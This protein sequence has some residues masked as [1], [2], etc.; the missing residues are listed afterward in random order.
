MPLPSL[1]RAVSIACV[2]AATVAIAQDSSM[3]APRVVEQKERAAPRAESVNGP[4]E[5]IPYSPPVVPRP[6][7]SSDQSTDLDLNPQPGDIVRLLDKDGQPTWTIWGG[8]SEKFRDFL[9]AQNAAGRNEPEFSISS[10]AM[11]GDA[12]DDRARLVAHITIQVERDAGWLSVSLGMPE[13][14]RRPGL[15]HTGP[16]DFLPVVPVNP[17]AGHIVRLRGKGVHE[18]TFPID[19]PIRR[20]LNQRHL[21][22]TIPPAA[23]SE[24]T[25]R[26]PK[27]HCSPKPI[28]GA[29]VHASAIPKGTQIE[30]VGVKGQFD[31]AWDSPVDEPQSRSV[32]DVVDKLWLRMDGDR[33]HLSAVQTI[34]PKRGELAA[35]K[36]RIPS[37][38]RTFNGQQFYV[39][40][41]KKYAATDRDGSGFVKVD[42]KPAGTSPLELHWEL[43]APLQPGSSFVLRGLDVEGARSESGD[44]AITPSEGFHF[45]YR[46]GRNVRRINVTG[47]GIGFAESAYSFW[48]PF[49]LELSLEEIRPQFSVEPTLYL[50]LSERQA[51]LTGQI[52]VQIHQGALREMAFNWP[53]WKKQ[54]WTVD[55]LP[56]DTEIVNADSKS[57]PADGTLRFR[58]IG[59]RAKDF[60][61]S[62]RA[63]RSIPR[64]GGVFQL[65]L[66]VIM[67][68]VRPSNILIVAEA[69]NVKSSFEPRP[70]T[71]GSSIASSRRDT[72][73]F[74][75]SVRGLRYS[76]R[77]VESAVQAFD[78]T[79]SPQKQRIESEST[80][81]ID[82]QAGQLQVLQRIVYQVSY[83][84]LAEATI[85]VPRELKK[86]VRFS[87]E[88]NEIES[89]DAR[90]SWVTTETESGDLARV[91]LKENRVG[92]FDLFAR[93][94]VKLGE[95]SATETSTEIPVPLL[96]SRDAAFKAMRV[97]LRA[98]DDTEAEVIDD[99]WSPQITTDAANTHAWTVAGERTVMPLR[100]IRTAAAAAPGLRITRALIRSFVD[101]SGA[102]RTNAA[103]H[104][105]SPGTTVALSIPSPA[106]DPRFWLDDVPLK[107]ERVRELRPGSGEFRLDIASLSPNS[108]RVLT[109]EYADPKGAP[110]GLVSLHR[111]QAPAFPDST[112]IEAVL[113][114]V[115]LPF[116]QFLFLSPAGFS[117]EFRWQRE[118]FVW[119]RK[120]TREAMDL[121]TT[122]GVSAREERGE[123]NTYV[124]SR[125][126]LVQGVVVGSIAQ[127]FVILIGAGLALLAAFVLMR[128]PISRT[129]LTFFLAAF[130]VAISYLWY[131]E[132]VRLLLQPALIGL[133]LAIIASAVEARF[134]RRR[135]P[136]LLAAASAADFAAAATS[137]SSIQRALVS[138]PD[139]ESP[140]I[141]RPGS[142]F[143]SQPVA[144][145][146]V[147]SSQ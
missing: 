131:P 113:W 41:P 31:L 141:N 58:L 24:F 11:D 8:T 118:G 40:E 23:A 101:I 32:F 35:V 17:S 117:P 99:T 87:W 75:E 93:Y 16:G 133:L 9:R 1:V 100:L 68:P 26:I 128:F 116:E 57:S 12:D 49:R 10:I 2:L 103:Y 98:G 83:E 48:Q 102:V 78:V 56:P 54:G 4:G 74:P 52:R 38:F 109:I 33:L 28:E 110:C 111:L 7:T 69:E 47:L 50:L 80:V 132:A 122:V 42:L 64:G 124:F 72:S 88:Q 60:T 94:S 145:S 53:D 137:P 104:L 43:E 63:V 108:Q 70:E 144:P 37:E 91:A 129:P 21:Q 77:R 59:G 36:V 85:I 14:R 139:A 147:G 136:F 30:A 15:Q 79:V 134:Q 89:A 86:N 18:L 71:V 81:R 61:F 29:I 112:T 34:E 6:K 25:L 46:G 121:G 143:G 105:E 127:S 140:T 120:P 45:D 135:A 39:V 27:E 51:E 90:P 84:R 92:T 125:Y 123:G 146:E 96:R 62:F 44:V 130:A 20:Q 138:A 5:P 126:G 67:A 65:T 114:E 76:S 22:L 13:A 55:V 19:V 106:G 115:T 3:R 82:V 95:P 107:A 73:T 97:E 119:T 66:P 142:Q